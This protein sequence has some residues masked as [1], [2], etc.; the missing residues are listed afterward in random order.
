MTVANPSNCHQTQEFCLVP[1]SQAVPK[2]P[3]P[4]PQQIC[5]LSTFVFSKPSIDTTN[6]ENNRGEDIF[7]RFRAVV[8]K[9]FQHFDSIVKQN[10]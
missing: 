6:Y 7:L 1:I 3:S 2:K 5:T 10:I 4:K 8:I 9:R